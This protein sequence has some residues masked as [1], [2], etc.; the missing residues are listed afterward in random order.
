MALCVL[1]GIE[2]N[3]CV[4]SGFG[5]AHSAAQ[6]VEYVNG[7]AQTPMGKLRALNG[8]PEP[9]NVKWWGIGN[10]MYG[11]WQLGHMSI[12][13]YVIK[14]NQF[15][16]AMRGVDPSIVIVAS[17]A[18]PFETSMVSRL[19]RKPLPSRLPFEYGSPEDWSGNLLEKSSGYFEYISEHIYPLTDSAF[20]LEAQ[21][22]VE[23]KD[24]LEDRVRRVPNRI[25]AAV[26]AWEEYLK[27]MPHLE[28]TKIKLVI[29][30]W[31]GGGRSGFTRTLCAAAG[32]HEMFRH[33]SII[34]MAAYTAFISAL[35]FDGADA[36][37]SPTGLVFKLYR[38]QFG[39]IPVEVG[40]NSPQREVKGTVGVDRPAVSSGS[41]TWPLDVSAALTDDRKALTVAVVNPT[42]S[43]QEADLRISGVALAGAATLWRI[44]AADLNAENKPGEK[45]Q[46]EIEEI[47]FER[48]PVALSV[49][50]RSISLYRFAT[51]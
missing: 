43:A 25:R 22:F 46:V 9:Y 11:Q 1:I 47:P 21:Q 38:H 18:S 13:H 23:V 28:D 37:Y 3:L 33:T 40:G 41:D 51:R 35:S 19:H 42:E 30:E 24:P 7:S 26:E 2:A 29:D 12:N 16:E 32:L 10:E 8:H 14:H 45:P 36:T 5:D 34:K 4:N 44:A 31:T 20:D 6:W 15:A 48:V 39:T 49:P 27:R 17:G 50:P